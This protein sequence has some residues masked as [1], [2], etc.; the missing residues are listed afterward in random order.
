MS[1]NK[2][3]N[4]ILALANVTVTLAN[5]TV[6]SEIIPHTLAPSDVKL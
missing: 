5:V 6:E 4:V 3:T 1:S 2:L